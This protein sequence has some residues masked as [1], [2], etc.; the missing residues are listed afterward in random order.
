MKRLRK[1]TKVIINLVRKTLIMI[2]LTYLI[3][4]ERIMKFIW[5]WKINNKSLRTQIISQSHL[6]LIIH[7]K[8]KFFHIHVKAQTFLN[9]SMHQVKDKILVYLPK[10]LIPTK[11]IIT[12]QTQLNRHQESLNV[13]VIDFKKMKSSI[14]IEDILMIKYQKHIHKK[15]NNFKINLKIMKKEY[16][17]IISKCLHLNY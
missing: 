14:I 11:I 13:A 3:T 15:I 10:L 1:S 6:K 12:I 16:K 2:K 9:Q 5:K 7:H 8:I 17:I 4:T